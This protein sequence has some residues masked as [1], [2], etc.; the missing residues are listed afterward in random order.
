M[1][2]NLAEKRGDK[3]ESSNFPAAVVVA[4][5]AGAAAVVVVDACLLETLDMK[6]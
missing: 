5:A 4:A 1:K 2:N 6:S 3:T